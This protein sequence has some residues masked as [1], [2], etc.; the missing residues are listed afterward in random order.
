MTAERRPSRGVDHLSESAKGGSDRTWVPP[1]AQPGREPELAALP[2]RVP[3][4]PHPAGAGPSMRAGRVEFPVPMRPMTIGD[5]L[6]GAFAVIK[7]RPRV[8]LTIVV[9]FVVP[10]QILIAYLQRDALAGL[11]LLDALDEPTQGASADAGGDLGLAISLL[12]PMLVLPFVAGAIARLVSAW[13]AGGDP[14][15][16]E[17]MLAAGRRWWALAAATLLA[18]PL[19]LAGLVVLVLPGLMVVTVFLV[20]APAIVV[21]DLGPIA[22]MR[23]SWRLTVRRFWPSMGVAVLSGLV[24]Y[25]MGQALG[26]V[27]TLVG[28][29]LSPAFGWI[30]VAAG[31]SAIALLT[32]PFVAAA[33]VLVYLDLRIRS[34]GLDLELAA[35]E[36]LT[37]AA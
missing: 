11:S 5:I 27:T 17:A 29:E 7:A 32:T 9:V 21:E 36:H 13:Y 23:R 22:G 6:D 25:L 28:A 14:S 15:A 24:A 33:T 1:E 31:T 18:L 4:Y 35:R 16:G 30:L 20:T 37:R 10:L 2:E 34:E 8:V 3:P 26:A 12:G 19:K